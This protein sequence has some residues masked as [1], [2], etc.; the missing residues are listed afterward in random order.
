MIMPM[1][2]HICCLPNSRNSNSVIVS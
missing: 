1:H 2:A